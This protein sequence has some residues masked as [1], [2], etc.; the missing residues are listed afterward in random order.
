MLLHALNSQWAPHSLGPKG[1]R[2]PCLALAFALY[3]LFVSICSLFSCLFPDSSLQMF[4][5]FWF[6]QLFM[7]ETQLNLLTPV[8]ANLTCMPS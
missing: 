4:P 2:M 1:H 3:F 6:G 8:S 7:F 5:Y